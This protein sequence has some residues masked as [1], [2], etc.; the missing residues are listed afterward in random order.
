MKKSPVQDPEETLISQDRLNYI[1]ASS[2]A[3]L[4]CLEAKR[5]H[6]PTFISDNV[7]VLFGY[8]PREYLGDRQ[9][10]MDRIHPDDAGRVREEFSHLFEKGYLVGEYRFRR[11]DGSY[12]W[13]R[14]ELRVIYADNGDPVEAVGSWSDISARKVAEEAIVAS[15]ARINHLLASSPAVL[16]CF[17]AKGKHAPTF[18]SENVRELFGYEPHEY[19]EDRNFVPDRI[20]PDDAVRVLGKLMHLFEDGYLVNEYRF[21]RK[22]GSYCWVSDELRIIYDDNGSPVEAV[23]SW[24]DISARKVVNEGIID[25]LSTTS[26]FSSL[27]GSALGDIAAEADPIH[28]RGGVKL[29]QEGDPG[30]SFYLV[31]SGRMITYI[32]REGEEVQLGEAGKGELVG[33]TAV[34]TGESQPISARAIRDTDLLQFSRE[35]FYRIVEHHPEAVLSISSNIAAR[36]QREI[37]GTRTDSTISTIAVIPAGNDVPLSEFTQRLVSV[38]SAVGS[39]VLLDLN[40]VEEALGKSATEQSEEDRILRWLDD[41]E[42]HHQ[43]II[44][45]STLRPSSWTDRCIRQADRILLVGMAGNSP[46]LNLIEKSLFVRRE[47]QAIARQEL[48]LLHP[49]RKEAPEKTRQWLNYRSVTNHHHIV[50]DDTEDYK[51]LCRFLT[52]SAICVVLGGGGARGCAHIGLIRALQELNVPI[53][54]IGGTS[55]GAAMGSCYA[56]GRNPDE[57]LDI[58]DRMWIMNNPMREYTLPIVSLISGGKLNSTLKKM[59]GNAHIEDLW[60]NYYSVSANLTQASMSIPGHIPPVVSNGELY[61]DGGVLDNLPVDIMREIFDGVIIANNVSPEIDLKVIGSSEGT[62]SGWRRALNILRP[63]ARKLDMPNILNIL[64]RAG[65]LSSIRAVNTSKAQADIYLR[66]PVDEYQLLDLAP[67]H[68]IEKAGYKYTRKVM[69]EQLQ[70][71][72]LLQKALAI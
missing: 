43:F 61:V 32:T 40:R 29:L 14:D 28:L 19:L 2:P 66:P 10:A 49:D 39:T 47:G 16:Y 60:V 67:A 30:S 3:V 9:F 31:T 11:K 53:D 57:I 50:I 35:A 45:E 72:D 46:A 64:M 48:V 51:R 58:I 33:E 27:D 63:S 6:A 20:H 23:G 17:D 44:Y 56:V 25:L 12:C 24:S 21:R 71:N 1:L 38:F 36:Y 41:Q 5:D 34:F 52:G 62:F 70:N 65:M 54:A 37:H 4:Y 13:V 15:Q 26:L 7:R 22:D 42:S 8:E 55:I 18:I 59:Y 69:E 68:E